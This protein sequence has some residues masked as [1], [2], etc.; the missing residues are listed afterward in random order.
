MKKLL[1]LLC[2]TIL[3]GLA[4][5]AEA[6]TLIDIYQGGTLLGSVTPYTGLI[7]GAANYNFYS[8]SGHPINGPEPVFKEGEI[9]FYDGSDGLNFNVIFSKEGIGGAAGSAQWDITI[10]GST[11]NLSVRV[12][13]DASELRENVTTHVFTGRWGWNNQNTD[14]GVI[15]EIGGSEWIITIDPIAYSLDNLKAYSA[16]G[17]SYA[18]NL[19]TDASGDIILKPASSPVPVPATILLFCSGFLGLLGIGGIKKERKDNT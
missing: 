16:S 3:F 11:T 15:G 10:T 6:T 7:T 5:L 14:G 9:F 17:S 12:T 13:D 19:N 8:D 2:V 4:G 1:G 18:L